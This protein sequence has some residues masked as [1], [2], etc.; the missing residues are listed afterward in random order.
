MQFWLIA[1]NVFAV[2][3]LAGTLCC[4]VLALIAIHHGRMRSAE[5]VPIVAGVVLATR[6]AM[7]CDTPVTGALAGLIAG[8]FAASMLIAYVYGWA[9]SAAFDKSEVHDGSGRF[10]PVM[11]VWTGCVLFVGV[12]ALVNQA[13]TDTFTPLKAAGF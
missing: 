5:W 13:A 4:W 11:L 9:R 2:F 6:W 10:A 3:A 8:W 7:I 1:L 12:V